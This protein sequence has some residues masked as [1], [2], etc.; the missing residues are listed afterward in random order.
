MKPENPKLSI[1]LSSDGKYRFIG[2]IYIEDTALWEISCAGF[3]SYNDADDA[4]TK[5][6]YL[7]FEVYL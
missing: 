7:P 3:E 6:G 4:R 2:S 1:C 5:Y